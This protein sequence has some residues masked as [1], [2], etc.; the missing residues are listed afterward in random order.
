MTDIFEN[1]IALMNETLNKMCLTE[2]DKDRFVSINTKD[3]NFD[4]SNPGNNVYTNNNELDIDKEEEKSKLTSQAIEKIKQSLKVSD[5]LQSLL[6]RIKK[7][8]DDVDFNEWKVNEEDNTAILRNKNAR[9]FKQNNN[10]CLSH[11]G[12]I[13]IFKSVA[14]LHDWLKKNNY[15][16]P[17]GIVLHESVLSE[18]KPEKIKNSKK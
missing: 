9:I 3:D 7:I 13:E 6:N 12:E 5:E 10:L 17:K 14:E 11:N 1:S 16:L 18:D 8:N 4:A 2:D 15:P